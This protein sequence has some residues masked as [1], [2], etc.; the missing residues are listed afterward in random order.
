M[1]MLHFILFNKAPAENTCRRFNVH[2]VLLDLLFDNG[3]SYLV[4][5]MAMQ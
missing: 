3:L 5:P 4:F 1:I 2:Q